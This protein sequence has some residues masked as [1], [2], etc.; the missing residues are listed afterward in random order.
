MNHSFQTISE[1][2]ENKYWNLD[3][4]LRHSERKAINME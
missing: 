4:E 1:K 3:D 2:T